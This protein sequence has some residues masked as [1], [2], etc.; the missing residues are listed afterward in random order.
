MAAE[1]NVKMPA[2][3][4]NA[5]LFQVF[6]TISFVLVLGMP[7]VLF[8]KNLGVSAAVLGIVLAL[9][10][11]LNILQLPAAPLVEKVGYRAFVLRGWTLRTC[12][13]LGMA[14]VAFLPERIEATTRIA[15]LLFLL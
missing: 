6:N 8:F 1:E 2:G 15:L 10:A 9:P 13:I 12:M 11:L 5:Y 4:G 7:M 14:G 3:I